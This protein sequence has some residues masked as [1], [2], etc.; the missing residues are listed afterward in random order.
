[1]ELYESAVEE[2]IDMMKNNTLEDTY[3][4]AIVTSFF[5]NG[6]PKLTFL[7]EEQES[8]KK[9]S[10]IYTYIPIL[11]DK[12]LLMK[13]NRTYII[14]GKIAYDITPD[15]IDK[16]YTDEDIIKLITDNTL[17]EEEIQ[18]LADDRI[19]AKECVLLENDGTIS[20]TS[21][22][23]NSFAN[24]AVSNGFKHTGSSVGFF[25]K[26]PSSQGSVSYL[27]SGTTDISKIVSRFN[28]LIDAIKKSGLIDDSG[29]N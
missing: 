23:Y 22:K 3:K 25:G 5:E 13:T 21:A 17:T 6:C 2:K 19:T 20:N 15:I 18:S 11:G 12:V 27:P 14:L 10:Y 24:L 9:Y 8:N 16:G 28:S 7:G 29:T 4:I 26:T 1:M